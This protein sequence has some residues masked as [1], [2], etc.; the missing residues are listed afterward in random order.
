MSSFK[1]DKPPPAIALVSN[2]GDLL[3]GVTLGLVMPVV[4]IACLY[5]LYFKVDI[6]QFWADDIG[7]VGATRE[8][9]PSP[10]L[11]EAGFP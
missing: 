3:A 1:D 9:L 10:G 2:N 7:G 8:L 5:P 6:W 11:Q 4:G